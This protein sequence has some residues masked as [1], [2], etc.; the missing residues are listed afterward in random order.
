MKEF[1]IDMDFGTQ[2]TNELVAVESTFK[3]DKKEIQAK[4]E[5]YV[6]KNKKQI[7]LYLNAGRLAKIDNFLKNMDIKDANYQKVIYFLIDEYLD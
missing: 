2:T 5:S 6:S 4:F 3:K 1:N 7:N